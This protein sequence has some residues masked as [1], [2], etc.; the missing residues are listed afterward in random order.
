MLF[1]NLLLK[2]PFLNNFSNNSFNKTTS[3]TNNHLQQEEEYFKW[4]KN[5]ITELQEKGIVETMKNYI[6]DRIKNPSMTELTN[7]EVLT[8]DGK[9]IVYRDLILKYRL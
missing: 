7:K 5:D 8:N 2:I 3:I 1:K 4:N 6:W 9:K